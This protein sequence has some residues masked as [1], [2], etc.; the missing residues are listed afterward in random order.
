[1]N[2]VYELRQRLGITQA[3]LADMAKTSQPTIA[4]YESGRKSPTLRTLHRMALTAGFDIVFQLVPPMTREERR[5]LHLHR[6]IA[7]KLRTSPKEVIAR[8]RKNLG[9]M[10]AQHPHATS[11]LHEWQHLL[12]LPPKQVVEAMLDRAPHASELRHITP[13]AGVLSNSER[14]TA[15]SSFR[16]IEE[17]SA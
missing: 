4:A 9:K 6:A 16:R 1:M 10:L 14:A 11:L 5:S 15:Y 17:E 2:A 3:E 12:D 7:E 13:F 8:A